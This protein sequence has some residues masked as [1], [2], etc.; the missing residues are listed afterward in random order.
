MIVQP[1]AERLPHEHPL[2]LPFVYNE[3][4]YSIQGE[5]TRAGMPCVFVR[6]HGC[7]LRCT[8]CD[9]TYAIHH[10]RGGHH[11]TGE[12]LYHRIRS[13]ECSF[14]EFTGGEPLEQINTFPLMTYLCDEGYTV[15][16][17]TGGHIDTELCDPR[18]IRIIDMK[19][20]SSKMVTLNNYKN[21]EILR[22]H[23][24]VKFV[25]GTREDYEWSKN[26]IEQHQLHKRTAAVLI[27]PVFGT[28][29]YRTLVEWILADHLPVRFQLQMHKFVWDPD[30]R[31]V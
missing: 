4:F 11:C 5:G 12:E 16:V 7:S 30:A 3:L 6:L 31:G 26:L 18:V 22:P 10:R 25:V 13:Y 29:E 28:V 20:P 14:V 24:E 2:T 23:D 8:Y 17:E 9:T 1:T 19:C 27:S 21:L 15:A